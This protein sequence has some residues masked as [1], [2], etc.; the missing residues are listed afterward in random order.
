MTTFLGG[1]KEQEWLEEIYKYHD[2]KNLHSCFCCLTV[3]YIFLHYT[4]KLYS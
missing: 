1:F 2:K 3:I 4:V